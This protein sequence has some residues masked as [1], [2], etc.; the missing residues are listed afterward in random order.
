MNRQ[1]NIHNFA[2]QITPV[3]ETFIVL[4]RKT[5]VSLGRGMNALDEVINRIL[6][7]RHTWHINLD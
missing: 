2:E 1:N 6:C 4:A 5:R 3:I 7:K